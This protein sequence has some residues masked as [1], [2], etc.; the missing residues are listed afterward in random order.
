[1][2]RPPINRRP[3]LRSCPPCLR[4]A[5]V[6]A[7]RKLGLCEGDSVRSRRWLGYDRRIGSWL[8]LAALLIQFGLSFGHFHP[9][10]IQRTDAAG[11]TLSPQTR[12]AKSF[13]TQQ[14]SQDGDDY[15]AICA[16]IYLA[17]NSFMP[18]APQLPVPS[19][20]HIVE[21]FERGVAVFVAPQRA[22]FQSRAPPLA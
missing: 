13:P 20:S 6:H 11:A 17:A 19:A 7:V 2:G 1:M 15:C 10:A 21:R 3:P 5:T 8:A 18:V 4:A 22:P 16:S 9:N 14:P 12:A